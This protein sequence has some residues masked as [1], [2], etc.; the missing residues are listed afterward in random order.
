MDPKLKLEVPQQVREFAEQ[1][2]DQAEKAISSFM[3][4]A[5]NSVAMVPG[6]MTDVAKQALV[7]TEANLKASFDHARKLMQAKDVKRS[8][9][10]SVGIPK[11]AV[12]SRGRAVQAD[13]QRH[14]QG[15]HDDLTI[16]IVKLAKP[17]WNGRRP[18][19][20]IWSA[21]G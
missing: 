17:E 19:P 8:D 2:V 20:K 7:I 10:T 16:A 6:P 14:R 12:W 1:S 4:S 15:N 18:T 9:A 5:G 13:D 21:N 3:Q 11:V